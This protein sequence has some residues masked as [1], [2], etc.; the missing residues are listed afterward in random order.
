MTAATELRVDHD[1][2]ATNV[3]PDAPRLSW[4]LPAMD[5]QVAYRVRVTRD[6]PSEHATWDSGRVESARSVDV[7][8]EGPPLSADTRYVWQ[9]KYWNSTS[10][11]RPWSE[12]AS[13]WTAPQAPFSGSWIGHQPDGGD[14]AGFRSTWE[15]AGDDPEPWIQLDLGAER[16]IERVDLFPASPIDGPETPDGV[17][18]SAGSWAGAEPFGFPTAVRIE[19]GS[20]ASLGDPASSVSAPLE[21]PDRGECES[22]DIEPI[23]GRYLRI[24]ATDPWV[25][26]PS[27]RDRELRTQRVREQWAT[28]A[29]A[30]IEVQDSAGDDCARGCQVTASSSVER[31][32]WGRTK[33][34]DGQQTSRFAGSAP[35]LR[36]EFSVDGTVESARL[37]AST[38]GYGDV[39]INGSRIGDHVLNPGWTDYRDRVLFDSYEV[40]ETLAQ[41]RNAVGIRLGRGWF[42]KSAGY[43]TAVGSPR[44]NL[45]LRIRYADG[46]LQRVRTDERW[47]A[48]SGPIRENDIY[49]GEC[50]DAR[51]EHPGWTEPGFEADNWEQAAIVRAPDGDLS[52]QRTPPIRVVDE[53]EPIGVIDHPEGPIVDFGQNHTGWVQLR[54]QELSRGDRVSIRYAEALD[55]NGLSR[56]DLRSARATDEYVAAGAES[57]VFE[58]RFTY[59]GYRYVQIAG[60]IDEMVSPEVVSRV[61]HTDLPDIGQ[62]DCSDERTTWIQENARRGLRSNTHSIPTDCPQRD[63]RLGWTGDA[64][65]A[66]RSL[67]FNFDG[68]NFHEKWLRD[69]RDAQADAGY[70]PPVVPSTNVTNPADPSWTVTAVVLP[71]YLYVHYGDDR[72]LAENYDMMRRYVEYWHE[73]AEDSIVPESYGSYGDWLAL[74]AAD[75]RRGAPFELFNTAHHFQSTRLLGEIADV[76]GYD[77]DASRYGQ[78]AATIADAFNDRFFDTTAGQYKPGTQS[79]HAIPLWY[80][81]APAESTE[82]LVAELVALVEDAGGALQTG[83]LGTRALINALAD[84]GHADLAYEVITRRERPGWGYMIEQGATTMWERW[85]SDDRVGSGMNSLNH[86]PFALVSEWFYRVPGGLRFERS[87]G[88]HRRV[89]IAPHFIS[90]LEWASAS[91]ETPYGHVASKWDRSGDELV[92]D[93]TVPGN[94]TADVHVPTGESRALELDGHPIWS[95]G[96]PSTVEE[97]PEHVRATEDE[98]RLVVGPGRYEFELA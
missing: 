40:S 37:H 16:S 68:R 82:A 75:G 11:E 76:L 23:A 5:E 53:L 65:L 8:Y 41:G 50:Y 93:V 92:L 60:D 58:P 88:E 18:V 48:A 15:P 20:D 33:I 38:L 45:E 85:D 46:R 1:R 91:V 86:S 52:P 70:L 39:N 2:G 26:E 47:R 3:P 25:H 36:T 87:F 10:E 81:L 13:F 22:I 74:E 98:V 49:D 14:S 90:D 84:H 63:E 55:D 67:C 64:Q 54:L 30:A 96:T 12:P 31:E 35:L 89:T 43:W 80:G 17:T 59:H 57:S 73:V 21:P 19:I 9:V 95:A 7:P 79:A 97:S 62:F 71:W 78:R 42:E 69:H 32:P 56:V 28:L 66:A 61:V 83:F 24:T 6:P 29:L 27:D 44:A 51:H 34:V 4:R 94:V 72:V 77:G